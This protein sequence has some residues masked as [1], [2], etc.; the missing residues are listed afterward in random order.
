MNSKST[1]L[2]LVVLDMGF[3][4]LLVL[5]V[6]AMLNLTGLTITQVIDTAQQ[7]VYN[8]FAFAN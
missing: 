2:I 1:R 7:V 6:F 8:A 5:L 4:S 3:L